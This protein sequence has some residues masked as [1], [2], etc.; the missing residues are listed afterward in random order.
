MTAS[1]T[2][3]ITTALLSE[4]VKLAWLLI[5]LGQHGEASRGPIALSRLYRRILSAGTTLEV[6]TERTAGRLGIDVLDVLAPI[7]TARLGE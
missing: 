6:W 4:G 3:H 5:R 7:T 2:K 1:I